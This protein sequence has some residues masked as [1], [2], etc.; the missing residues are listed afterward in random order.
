M[1][2]SIKPGDTIPVKWKRWFKEDRRKREPW[3]TQAKKDFDFAAGR[4]WDEKD[5]RVLEDE[6]RPAITFNR[7]TVVLDAVSGQEIQSK[8]EIRYLP[9]EQ[10]D[11]EVN[12]LYSEAARWFDDESEA[13]DEESE[14]FMDTII[15]GEGWTEDRLDFDDDPDGAP[16]CERVDPL[17]MFVDAHARKSNYRD[18]RRKWRVKPMAIDQIMQEIP[19]FDKADYD[20]GKWLNNSAESGENENDPEHYYENE[21][22]SEPERKVQVIHLQYWEYESFYRVADMAT[23]QVVEMDESKFQSLRKATMVAMGTE[24]RFVKLRRK[25]Y[26]QAII[27]SKVLYHGPSACKN[28][29]TWNCITGKRDNTKN[30]FY[31]LIRAMR[32]PQMWANKWMSQL[33]H[34]MNS[35]AKGGAF[36][37]EGAFIDQRQAEEDYAKPN[38]MIP[39]KAGALAQGKILERQ[40]SQYPAGY[41]MLTDMAVSAVRDVTGVS[42]ELMG[43]RETTQ[44]GVLEYQRRQAG[45]TVLATL[46]NSLKKYRRARGKV[47]L[48]YIT[49]YLSDGRLVK[50]VG[51]DGE[52]YVP[53]TKQADVKYDVIIDDAPQ[54][55]NQKEMVW[56]TVTQILPG[57][58]DM[59]PPQVLL[60]L[61]DY[62]PIPASVVSKIKD[63]VQA[64]NPEAEQQAQMAARHAMLELQQKE[65]DLAK[66]QSETV[67]N[68]REAQIDEARLAIEGQKVANENLK[69]ESDEIRANTDARKLDIDAL[70]G[71]T[72][73][74]GIQ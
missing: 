55:P 25:R 57:I 58:R 62:S 2:D 63:V 3:H 24:P 19:G 14:A 51:Q 17:E 71:V 67:E 7:T 6:M 18:A 26:M 32:D 73:A 33:L 16:M 35:N 66:T 54:S 36:Y 68:Q 48:H 38:A 28:G 50:I 23:D 43:M 46:F 42:L 31:G 69:V 56:Q 47:L 60:E 34:I 8:Q 22:S 11:V 70:R 64:P 37:E 1:A 45:M 21:A 15:A 72:P 10:G 5:K 53:L 74:G 27:G 20:A 39:V 61:L 4:Q 65:A 40:P 29:F 52:Q 13:A 44:P 30:E 59:I 41:Q 9:R 12:E 49:E